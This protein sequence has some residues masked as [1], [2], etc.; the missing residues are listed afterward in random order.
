M[1]ALS[2]GYVLQYLETFII[3][4]RGPPEDLVTGPVTANTDVIFIE[5]THADTGRTNAAPAFHQ[6]SLPLNWK[7]RRDCR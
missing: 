6:L 4:H 1:F 3:R 5:R 7:G 2:V